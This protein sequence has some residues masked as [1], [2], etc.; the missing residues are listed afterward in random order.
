MV[1]QEFAIQYAYPFS[2]Q[3]L[4]PRKC[5]SELFPHRHDETYRCSHT[6]MTGKQ[7][8]MSV[9]ATSIILWM[10]ILFYQ[11][12]LKTILSTYETIDSCCNWCKI[13]QCCLTFKLNLTLNVK[14]N[15]P[16]PPPPPPQKKKKKKKT[17]YVLFWGWLPLT[18]K[19]KFYLK[20]NILWCLVSPP[21]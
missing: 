12:P 21:D 19:V 2:A 17:Q 8:A 10:G 4:E 13:A 20:V 14:I 18:F 3:R 11:N 15:N 16:P 6:Y 7:K 9:A 1:C 5:L